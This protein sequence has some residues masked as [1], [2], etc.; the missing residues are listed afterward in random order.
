MNLKLAV[1]V[2]ASLSLFGCGAVEDAPDTSEPDALGTISNAV[3][4]NENPGFLVV[5]NV[6]YEN[7]PTA[8]EQCPGDWQDLI[9]FMKTQP[10]SPDVLI[11]HQ[12][13][14]AG[15]AAN[16][17]KFM[18]DNLPGLYDSVVS[19]ANPDPMASPCGAAKA[20]QTNAIIYRT[21]RLQPIAGSKATWQVFKGANG[22][23]VMNTQARS[24]GMRMVFTD[25]I[26]DKKVI[27]GSSHW[28][29]NQ[30]GPDG[31]AGCAEKN[32][33]LTDSKMRAP[34]ADLRI[35]GMDANESDHNGSS[36]KTWYN[37]ANAAI[38]SNV[39][40]NWND[41]IYE[42]CSGGRGCLDNNWTSGSH[43]RI[44]F[45]FFSAA[46]T[47]SHGH[48]VSYDEAD[49]A[50]DSVVGPDS[51]NHNYSDHRAQSARIHY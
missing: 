17:A 51:N 43:A 15:Q 19:E 41:P 47:S 37:Q 29:T 30:E 31:D 50:A 33:E 25:V 40:Y 7:L 46:S 39:N 42:A 12:M 8:D 21:G 34:T 23:C 28:P 35:W 5:Y 38:P 18:Q 1:P 20:Q 10:Y 27:L 3:A 11:V 6:N 2:V 22:K 44:D 45:L 14:G 36:Y 48:T 4:V 32:I 26:N 9:Y 16:L 13:S 24:I 49:A